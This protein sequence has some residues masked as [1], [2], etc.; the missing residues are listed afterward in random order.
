MAKMSN[1]FILCN[2]D[3]LRASDKALTSCGPYKMKEDD[4]MVYRRPYLTS[5]SSGFALNAI[6]RS[7]RKE[8]KVNLFIFKLLSIE[9]SFVY[10]ELLLLSLYFTKQI[11]D[12]QKRYKNEF[13]RRRNKIRK[14]WLGELLFQSQG[15]QY[16]FLHHK[17][18]LTKMQ[19]HIPCIFSFQLVLFSF[20]SYSFY[21]Y[22]DEFKDSYNCDSLG[23]A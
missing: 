20:T 1:D 9:L 18:Y 22:Y 10:C 2:E 6:S 7:M 3:P 17:S 12:A 23:Q 5:G 19:R 11:R 4:A 13:G 21:H 16:N 8:L 14:S 15:P